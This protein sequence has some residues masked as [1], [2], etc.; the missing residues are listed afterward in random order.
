VT[1]QMGLLATRFANVRAD[2]EDAGAT[3]F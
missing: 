3:P 2:S 1:G